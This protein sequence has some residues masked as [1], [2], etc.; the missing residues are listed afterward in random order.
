MSDN[1]LQFRYIVTIQGGLD[2]L[3]RDVVDVFVAGDLL[4]YPVEGDNTICQGPDIMVAFGRPKGYRGSYRQWEEGGIAPQV[5][6]ETLSPSNRAGELIR[7]F[8]FYERY[9]VEEYYVY[10]P[11]KGELIGYQRAGSELREIPSVAGWTSPRL[12]VRFE[13]VNGELHLFGPDGRRFASYVE[14]AEQRDRAQRE[15]EQLAQAL[16]QLRAQLRELGAEPRS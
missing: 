13:L 6:F 8:R 12:K 14:L 3:Y 5:V 2:A 15:M 9:G 1:T 11:D 16:E 4:W 10:D 7:K